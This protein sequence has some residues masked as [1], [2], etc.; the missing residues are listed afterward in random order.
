MVDTLCELPG[1]HLPK[2][3]LLWPRQRAI[4]GAAAPF[5]LVLEGK[6]FKH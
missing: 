5:R 6:H 3:R 4:I 2:V 1:Y